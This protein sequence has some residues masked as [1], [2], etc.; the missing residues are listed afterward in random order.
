MIFGSSG[1]GGS[2]ELKDLVCW[3]CLVIGVR[4]D[5]NGDLWVM[6]N[7]FVVERLVAVLEKDRIDND[8]CNLD[9]LRTDLG[10][11]LVNSCTGDV[12]SGGV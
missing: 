5:G 8:A 1:G 10:S 12:E 9:R 3:V 6:I 2:S 11:I 7:D 4:L